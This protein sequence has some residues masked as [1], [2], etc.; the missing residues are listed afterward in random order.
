M[1]FLDLSDVFVGSTDDGHTF[2]VLNR[3]VRGADKTLT[4]AGFHRQDHPG[5]TL[6]LLPPGLPEEANTRVGIATDGLLAHTH[7]LVDLSW[8]TRWDPD[9]PDSAA[10][11]HV[12]FVS[13][14]VTLTPKSATA[15]SLLSQHTGLAPAAD[16]SFR[17]QTGLDQRRQLA[18]VTAIETHAY[19]HSLKVHIDLGIPTPSQI[20]A[21][22]RHRTQT[23]TA[24]GVPT[25]T[26]VRRRPR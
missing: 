23:A 13:G 8:T 9:R 3:R 17:P 10:D 16:G 1:T 25:S 19:M 4:E 12:Q 14:T 7:D 21:G 20:P 6:Y 22:T 26:T 24:T 2:V 11:L 5:R 15:R 18:I